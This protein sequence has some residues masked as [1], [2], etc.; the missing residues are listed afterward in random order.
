MTVD[1][2]AQRLFDGT[3]SLDAVASAAHAVVEQLHQEAMATI[4]ALADNWD[5]PVEDPPAV[6]GEPVTYQDPATW[7]VADDDEYDYDDYAED[8]D[9]EVRLLHP[10]DLPALLPLRPRPAAAR[11]EP[12]PAAAQGLCIVGR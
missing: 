8:D 2:T 10:A 6:E 4:A 1:V 11:M 12:R 3:F 7:S 9:R 5:S